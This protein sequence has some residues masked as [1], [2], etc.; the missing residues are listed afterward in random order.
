VSTRLEVWCVEGLPEFGAGDDIGSA[1]AHAEPGLTDDDVVVVTSKVVSKA[2]GRLVPGTRDAHIAAETARVVAERGT[3]AIVETRH[4]FVL[5]AAGIDASNVPAG[6]VA[7]LPVDP[8]GSAV[9]IRER[10]NDLLGVD[11]AVLV[12]DTMGRPWRAGLVDAAIG[13][14][15]IEVL[16]DLR[17]LDDTAGHRLEA[18]V[19]A[20]ADELA[21]AAD[22]VKGK[23]GGTPVAVIRGLPFPRPTSDDGARPLI[24]PA[25][26]D[27]FRTGSR[28]AKLEVVADSAAVDVDDLD[29]DHADPAAVRRA[30]ERIRD[31]SVVLTV[32]GSGQSVSATGEPFAVGVAVGRLLGSVAAEGLRAGRPVV[33]SDGRSATVAVGLLRA[34]SLRAG[35]RT[36]LRRPE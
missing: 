13:A 20:V 28:E 21:A 10:I 33:T 25:V 32:D 8:D 17:G 36:G 9:Q 24:R 14:A 4:G 19:I 27:L 23:L 29:P 22:L 12:T 6:M 5:A 34:G 3:T 11:V 35:A 1:I 18:T 16:S 26:E 7:L 2:E 15:G 30:V 31:P